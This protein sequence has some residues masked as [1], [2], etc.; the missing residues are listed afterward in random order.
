MSDN[1]RPHQGG[2]YLRQSDGSLKRMEFT[3]PPTPF[4]PEAPPSD[5][6]PAAPAASSAA[7]E[8]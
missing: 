1:E 8:S 7:Q 2:S 5:P 3:T 4:A 6:A